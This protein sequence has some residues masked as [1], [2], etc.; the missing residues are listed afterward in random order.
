MKTAFK[1]GKGIHKKYQQT[2]TT[3]LHVGI[4]VGRQTV[5]AGP[6]TCQMFLGL[7]C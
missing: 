1:K 4:G 3:K 2:F 7:S 5:I 6:K